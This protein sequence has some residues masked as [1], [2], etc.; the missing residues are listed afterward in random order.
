[1][2]ERRKHSAYFNPTF[3]CECSRYDSFLVN[4]IISVFFF[5]K[6]VIVFSELFFSTK[7]I[8]NE[9]G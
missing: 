7:Y 5:I 3:L 1:M 8:V 2:K 6:D 4:D 9:F